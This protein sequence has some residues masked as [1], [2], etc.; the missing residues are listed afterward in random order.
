M[1]NALRFQIRPTGWG[2]MLGVLLVAGW[3]L[4]TITCVVALDARPAP[5]ALA[6]SNQSGKAREVAGRRVEP[7]RL[8]AT[9]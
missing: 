2:F 8:A 6:R 3:M 4:F 7:A 9:R 1:A 5:A